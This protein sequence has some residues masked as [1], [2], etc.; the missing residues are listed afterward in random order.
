MPVSRIHR[1]VAQTFAVGAYV[2]HDGN[3]ARRVDSARC[4]INR[5]LTDGDLDP[6]DAPIADPEDLLGIGGQDEIDFAGAG[7]QGLRM[8]LRFLP[9]H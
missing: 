6:S 3:H 1:V 4:C 2:D 5:E 9:V 8:P 7:V